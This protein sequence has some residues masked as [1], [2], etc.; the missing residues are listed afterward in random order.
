MNPNIVTISHATYVGPSGAT[1]A[2]TY[3][4]FTKGYHP[5]Q[6]DRA[7]D[8]DQVIN[9]NGRFKYI[10]D[11]GPGFKK[12]DPFSIM[13]ENAFA[14]IVGGSALVQYNRLLEMWNYR[15]VLGLTTPEATYIANWGNT[16]EQNF[17]VFPRQVADQIE[18]EVVV[19]F[20]EG[21]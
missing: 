13:C 12:W 5:P 17:R 9:Q 19:Q 8:S 11:N 14:S 4:F 2:A 16:L 20:E 18:Y 15:G 21:Q 3:K 1:A 6:A 7:I 10:Y